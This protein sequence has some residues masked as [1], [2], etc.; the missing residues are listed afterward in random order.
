MESGRALLMQATFLLMV[1]C[2]QFH[3]ASY[4]KANS[5]DLCSSSCGSI[6]NITSPFRLATDP[7]N[8][9]DSRFELSCENNITVLYLPVGSVYRNSYDLEYQRYYVQAINYNNFTIRL[10]D[11]NIQKDDFCSIPKN[12]LSNT[13]LIYN[14]ES[15]PVYEFLIRLGKLW[16]YDYRHISENVIFFTCESRVLNSSYIDASPCVFNRTFS[17]ETSFLSSSKQYYSYYYIFDDYSFRPEELDE[18][19]WIE[20]M[21][22]V[23]KGHVNKK[24]TSNNFHNLLV[25]GFELSWLQSF[26]TTEDDTCYVDEEDSNRVRCINPCWFPDSRVDNLDRCGLFYK[27]LGYLELYLYYEGAYKYIAGLLATRT[28]VGV[29]FVVA[30]II[31]KWRRRHLSTYDGIEEFLQGQ[32]NLMPIRYSFREIKKM[33][34]GFKDK[35]GEGGFGSVY[36]GKLSSGRFAAIKILIKSKAN[37][38]DFINEI[39]TIGRIHHVNVVRLI[40]FCVEGSKRALLYDF[41][42]LGSLDK[43][44]FSGEKKNHSL[45]LDKIFE[46]ALGVARGIEYLHRGCD[47]QI[48]HFDI[49]PHNILLDENFIPKVS[50]FG[51]ARLCPLDNSIVSL[52]AARGTIGYIAPELFYKNIGGVSYKADVYS[53]GMLL[54]EMASRRKNLSVNAENSSQIYFPSWIYDQFSKRHDIEMEDLKEDEKETIKKMIIVALWCIQLKPCDRPSMSKVIEMLEGK[55]E[56]LQMPPKPSFCPQ[57]NHGADARQTSKETC[58]SALSDE[59][60]SENSLISNAC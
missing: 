49:K 19:C 4:A 9:G 11:P 32:N 36:K 57:E 7:S 52:T 34:Q 16:S 27:F 14:L 17:S 43:Y 51:L 35:L 59:E 26:A 23:T 3:G 58:S 38:Q 50:D 53:F 13:A 42:P 31:Y 18:S 55:V 25:Y 15:S 48:L 5:R 45:S 40:G 54:M 44:I 10:V 56:C 21:S 12:S 33:T 46:I 41:M 1:I 8:C 2:M 22:L 60:L 47:M 6:R 20:Q 30:L 24:P 29:S 39:A 28:V 37:G